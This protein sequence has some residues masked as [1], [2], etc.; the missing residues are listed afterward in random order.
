MRT[1]IDVSGFTCTTIVKLFQICRHGKRGSQMTTARLSRNLSKFTNQTENEGHIYCNSTAAWVQFKEQIHSKVQTVLYPAIYGGTSTSIAWRK[2]IGQPGV[3][4]GTVSPPQWG[5][6]AKPWKFF[7]YFAFWIAQNI[8]LLA[9]RQGTLT[10]VY[11]RNQHF[12][13]FG[14]LNLG[15][16][17]SIPPSK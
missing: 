2:T 10:K 12:W 7:G 14:G 9:L 11:T 3:W 6:G 13:A 17:T 16:Q 15:S 5:P 4:G 1:R 8:A